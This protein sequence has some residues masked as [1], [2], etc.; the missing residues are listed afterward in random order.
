MLILFLNDFI[1]C[2]GKQH[3]YLGAENNNNG[4]CTH[5]A[6]DMLFEYHSALSM[7]TSSQ[8]VMCT[9]KIYIQ[10]FNLSLGQSLSSSHIMNLFLAHT[11]YRQ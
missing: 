8:F 9:L 10:T 5:A 2:L 3:L 4:H 11:L 6:S 1:G 7:L